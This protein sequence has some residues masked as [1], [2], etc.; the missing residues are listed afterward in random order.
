MGLHRL[1]YIPLMLLAVGCATNRVGNEGPKTAFTQKTVALMIVPTAE[2]A[3]ILRL[4]LLQGKSLPP[5]AEIIPIRQLDQISTVLSKA[6]AELR[7][8]DVSRPI[9][10]TETTLGN[11]Y[12]VLQRGS[13]TG[14]SCR[15]IEPDQQSFFQKID[16]KGGEVLIGLLSV[17][18][19]LLLIALPFILL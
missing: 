4:S 5:D 17:G 2:A 14:N 19:T 18:L 6:A 9:P 15:P 13:A 10:P 3:E 7:D 11:A 12:I 8:C 1:F 16:E